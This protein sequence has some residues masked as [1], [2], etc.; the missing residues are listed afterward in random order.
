MIFLKL[1]LNTL[2]LTIGAVSLLTEEMRDD[3]IFDTSHLQNYITPQH[4]DIN[5]S[6]KQFFQGASKFSGTCIIHIKI[7]KPTSAIIFHA[8][9][10]Q[11]EIRNTAYLIEKNSEKMYVLNK[12]PAY[13]ISFYESYKSFKEKIPIGN[14]SIHIAFN[15]S[16]DDDGGFFKTSYTSSAG[17]KK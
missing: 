3:P 4:Y 14:Y 10:P 11:I 16:L 5:I 6:L 17:N 8:Q 15:S 1:L 9:K 13:D 7:D 2:L 12:Y